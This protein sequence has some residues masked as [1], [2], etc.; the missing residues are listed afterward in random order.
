MKSLSTIF[1]AILLSLYACKYK[2][3]YQQVN[4]GNQFTLHIPSWLKK[5]EKLAPGAP[6]QYANRY[7]NFYAIGMPVSKSDSTNFEGFVRTNLERLKATLT[8]PLVTDSLPVNYSG[9][10]GVRV[11][12][13][14]KMDNESIYFSEVYLQTSKQYYHLSIWTR[15]E[16]RKLKFKDDI[17]RILESFK[18]I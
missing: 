5:D 1:S 13:W 17:E 16:E 10:K 15:G 6:F 18:E 9:A 2:N 14:G 11:E 12:I 4:A 7:R 3:E 8:N